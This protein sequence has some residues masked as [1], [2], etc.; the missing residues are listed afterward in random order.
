MEISLWDNHPF[1]PLNDVSD[2][3]HSK[4][5]FAEVVTLGDGQGILSAHGGVQPLS[6]APEIMMSLEA[7]IG[8]NIL[9]AQCGFQQMTCHS[10]LKLVNLPYLG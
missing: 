4:N 6:S 8:R 2:G 5:L 10:K 9:A 1:P 3:L 7:D